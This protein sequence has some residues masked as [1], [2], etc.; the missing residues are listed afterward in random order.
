MARD[1]PIFGDSVDLVIYD[2]IEAKLD[3]RRN[4]LHKFNEDSSR[5][6]CRRVFWTVEGVSTDLNSLR[7]RDISKQTRNVKRAEKDGEWVHIWS[8]NDVSK[9]ERVPY[10]V[11]Q[12]ES[13]N[14]FEKRREI[15]VWLMLS[16][17]GHKRFE[18]QLK[19]A[20]KQCFFAV[21]PRVVYSTKQ[22]F[23][24]TNKDILPALQNIN[25]ILFS[26]HCDRR[27]VGRTSL[28]LKDRI[29]QH[30][31]NL[32]ALTLLPGNAYFLPIGEIFHSAEYPISCFWFSHWISSFTKSS[33]C[34]AF[35]DS[36]FTI[37]AQGRSPYHLSAPALWIHVYQNF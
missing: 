6:R 32:L 14:R 16:W 26:C 24:A 21:E 1:D 33:L 11:A 18:K 35:D 17:T 34:S 30:V 9:G 23:C 12:V 5:K 36:R 8:F 3:R 20:V 2:V 37:L 25:L 29:K 22:H 15:F 4:H 7:L 28:R 19:S 13:E 27:Y 31:P 10:A